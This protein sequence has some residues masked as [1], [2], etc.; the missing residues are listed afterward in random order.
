MLRVL[1][2]ISA[3]PVI[4]EDDDA[5]TTRGRWLEQAKPV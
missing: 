3:S 1:V 4:D 5:E 2:L